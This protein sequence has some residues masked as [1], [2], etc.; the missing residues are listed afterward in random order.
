MTKYH[1]FQAKVCGQYYRHYFSNCIK[2]QTQLYERHL[3]D[4]I[5]V[6]YLLYNVHALEIYNSTAEISLSYNEFYPINKVKD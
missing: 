1:N 2:D 4:F 5:E 3:P 6:V